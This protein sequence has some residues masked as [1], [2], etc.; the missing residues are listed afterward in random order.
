MKNSADQGG[1][2]VLVDKTLRAI[3]LFVFVLTSNN[4]ISSPGFLGKPFNNLH[5]ASLLMPS[6]QYKKILS[7]FG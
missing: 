6:V 1:C 3:S 4:T 5:Q 2:S 7:K